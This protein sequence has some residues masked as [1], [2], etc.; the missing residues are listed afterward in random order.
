V[1]FRWQY[2]DLLRP[3]KSPFSPLFPTLGV[4]SCFYLML[5]LP[6]ITWWRFLIWSLLGFAIYFMYSR[7]HSVLHR[8]RS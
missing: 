5:S 8:E 6:A 7:Q 4:L 3:F 1:V 2:P